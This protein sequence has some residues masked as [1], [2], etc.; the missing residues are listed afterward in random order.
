MGD[1]AARDAVLTQSTDTRWLRWGT[2]AS[3]LSGFPECPEHSPEVQRP[4]RPGREPGLRAEGME[5]RRRTTGHVSHGSQAQALSALMPRPLASLFR[6]DQSL[7]ACPLGPRGHQ[8]QG[9]ESQNLVPV[10]ARFQQQNSQ[11]SRSRP[12]ATCWAF[13]T[14]TSGLNPSCSCCIWDGGGCEN[15]PPL[16]PRAGS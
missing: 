10:R 15:D 3:R 16:F 12:Q 6:R 5:S 9:R 14:P 2:G 1:E 4:K 11:H 7:R 8:C 13:G